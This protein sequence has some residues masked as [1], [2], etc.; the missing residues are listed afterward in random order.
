MT[1]RKHV[2]LEA[3]YRQLLDDRP[4][5]AVL[6]WGATEAHN[7]HLPHGTDVFEAQLL[8]EHAA[9]AAT[10]LGQKTKRKMEPTIANMSE[11]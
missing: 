9:G 4:N 3:N 7:Y 6:P 2:L 1:P 5:V 10:K 8:A 11:W